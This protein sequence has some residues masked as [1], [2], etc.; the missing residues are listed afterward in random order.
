MSNQDVTDRWQPH[1]CALCGCQLMSRRLA[2]VE[3]TPCFPRYHRSW[4]RVVVMIPSYKY[5]WAC[6]M[7][8]NEERSSGR[9]N[10]VRKN[11]I[12]TRKKHERL[13]GCQGSGEG[14]GE[15]R[16]HVFCILQLSCRP[17]DTGQCES[18][19]SFFP[20]PDP[21]DTHRTHCCESCRTYPVAFRLRAP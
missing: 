1:Y 17:A 14:G 7:H 11:S 3:Q 2:K 15:R 12:L 5:V 16:T 19:L 8:Y 18:P 9:K 4:N 20:S 21:S 6:N 10:T 13:R